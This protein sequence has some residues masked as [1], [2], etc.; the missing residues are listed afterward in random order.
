MKDKKHPMR[1]LPKVESIIV[2]DAPPSEAKKN[3]DITSLSICLKMKT[4]TTVRALKD[5]ILQK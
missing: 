5:Q 1:N 3:V 2:C 4:F